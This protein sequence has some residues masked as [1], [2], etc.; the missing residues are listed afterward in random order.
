MANLYERESVEF[1]PVEVKLDGQVLA[2]G[3]SY[4]IVPDGER[5]VTF[6]DAVVLGGKTGVM[7]QGLDR[8]TYRIFAKVLNSPEVPVMDCG[9]FY[10]N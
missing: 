4:A 9:Y 6:T 2:D 3:I 10:V 7:I 8:G 5:P 1:Q